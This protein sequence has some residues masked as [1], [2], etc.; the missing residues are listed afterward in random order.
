MSSNDNEVVALGTGTSTGVPML[1]CRCEVCLSS[2]PKNHRFRASVALKTSKGK[3]IIVDVTPD[4]RSQ[5]LAN[6]IHSCDAC[7][8]TH[9][10]ADHTHGID[11]LRPLSFESG[12]PIPVY[13]WNGCAEHLSEKFPYIFQADKLFKF[14]P[15]LGGGIPKLALHTVHE[16]AVIA[17]DE[18]EFYLLPHGHTKSLSFIHK[19]LGYAIDCKTVP[20]EWIERL[21]SAN[22]DLLILDCVKKEPHQTHLHLAA[23]L[24]IAREVG[25]KKTALIH[26]GHEL[27]HERLEKELAKLDFHVFPLF[28]GQRLRYGN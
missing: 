13:T 18:F 17:G 8:I 7:V 27:E 25:A 16:S 21:K 10:H 20:K 3:T 14:K 12:D 6:D 24:E 22:L 1:G 9:E 11:D 26:M 23:S 4:F 2:N 15:I 19:K 28:D 5:L